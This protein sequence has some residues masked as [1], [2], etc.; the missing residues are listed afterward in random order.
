MRQSGILAAAA[1]HALDAH[2]DRLQS[3]HA[4]ARAFA[5]LVEGAAGARVVAPDTY[6]VMV[7]LPD[8]VSCSAVVQG[9]K[10]AGV[11]LSPWHDSRIGAV[12]H[13]DV[14]GDAAAAAGR[15]VRDVIVRLAG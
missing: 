14:D 9:A 3:D 15:T 4:K 11:L 1:L 7:D 8:G 10:A 13:L 6:I 12:T 5:A 2:L